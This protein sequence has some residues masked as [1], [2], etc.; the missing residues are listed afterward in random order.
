MP[1]QESDLLG[2]P[3]CLPFASLL[4]FGKHITID[5]EL[6]RKLLVVLAGV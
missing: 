2:F 6:L 3:G 5:F 4:T 1:A